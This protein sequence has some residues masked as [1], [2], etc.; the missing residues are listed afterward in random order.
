MT[1][2]EFNKLNYDEKQAVVWEKGLF[3]D[4]YISKDVRINC[5]AL[6]MC[7]SYWDQYKCIYYY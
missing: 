7:L 4:N 5:Y 1:L 6:D 2:Y 3:L